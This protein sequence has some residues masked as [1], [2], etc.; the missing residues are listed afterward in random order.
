MSL[1]RTGLALALILVAAPAFA[2]DARCMTTDDGSY[3]CA[4]K[5]TDKAGSFIISA[6]GKP[7]F[8]LVMDA[9]GV[10]FGFATFETG[11]RSVPLPGQYLRADDDPACWDNTE[12]DTRICAW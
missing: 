11:G 2:K 1:A 3:P 4:F 9:P 7:T 12:T 10:A 5:A 8:E 6:P